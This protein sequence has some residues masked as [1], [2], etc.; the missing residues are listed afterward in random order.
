M[1]EMAVTINT[2]MPI[3]AS[4]TFSGADTAA[5][6]ITHDI[7][8]DLSTIRR[9]GVAGTNGTGD[10]GAGNFGNYPLYLLS[11]AG[12]SLFFNGPVSSYIARGAA[13]DAAGIT[14]GEK[15]TAQR[16]GVT[17]P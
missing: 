3:I 14:S 6:T 9:N 10:K 12:T 8:G 5:L 17:L 2:G 7:A 15:W 11:R 13:T 16:I 1:K 4:A